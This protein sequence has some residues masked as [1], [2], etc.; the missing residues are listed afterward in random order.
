MGIVQIEYFYVN[1]FLLCLSC[2]L[3]NTVSI[4]TLD[5]LGY[6]LITFVLSTILVLSL[7]QYSWP[8]HEYIVNM[9]H[10]LKYLSD[11]ILPVYHSLHDHATTM[12][13]AN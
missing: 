12:F 4:C 9:F 6:F 8:L 7:Y 13:C 1:T 3:H 11:R 2:K 10:N 5:I